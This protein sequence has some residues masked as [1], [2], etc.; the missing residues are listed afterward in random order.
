MYQKYIKTWS[1]NDHFFYCTDRFRKKWYF[2]A[3]SLM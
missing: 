3:K 2:K 1:F